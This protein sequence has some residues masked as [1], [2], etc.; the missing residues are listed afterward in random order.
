MSSWA[1]RVS[2]SAIL[3]YAI[4]AVRWFQT[5]RWTEWLALVG[6]VATVALNETVKHGI[7][8][9]RSPR[10]AN[11]ADCNLWVNDGPCGGKPGMPSGH[12]A[13]VS[14][15]AAY[16]L[17]EAFLTD[18]QSTAFRTFSVCLL[19][20]ALAVMYSRY[21]KECHTPIQIL[22]GALLGIGASVIVLKKAY[23]WKDK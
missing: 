17:Q 2:L 9:S 10:P 22:M 15:L 21:V 14:F 3:L 16:Y 19:F 6:M 7:V 4:P 13:Q 8:G 1:N 12:S 5:G 20:Y 18:T 23:Q 11:A